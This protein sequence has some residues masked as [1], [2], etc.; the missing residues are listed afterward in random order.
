MAPC[1]FSLLKVMSNFYQMD[2]LVGEVLGIILIR[3][4]YYLIEF[5]SMCKGNELNE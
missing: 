2:C 3:K 4:A 5:T 1:F